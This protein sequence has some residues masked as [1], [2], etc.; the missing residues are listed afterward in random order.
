[1]AMPSRYVGI[2]H[3]FIRLTVH[4]ARAPLG[5][6]STRSPRFV[7]TWVLKLIS[8]CCASH[9]SKMD[10]QISAFEERISREGSKVEVHEAFILLEEHRD[11]ARNDRFWPLPGWITN[12]G[13]NSL[14]KSFFRRVEG[15]R[16]GAVNAGAQPD[17]AALNPSLDPTFA[18]VVAE[19]GVNTPW[20]SS[21]ALE[22]DALRSLYATWAGW[23][24]GVPE[25]CFALPGV[26][27]AVEGQV[28]RHMYVYPPPFVKLCARVNIAP[29]RLLTRND[30]TRV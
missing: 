23:R 16:R 6:R 15:G 8:L 20:Q 27:R 2:E 1:M 19:A 17:A 18:A 9:R 21:D 7:I 5:S 10:K 22:S 14:R 28:E 25:P 4:H 12:K 29:P 3:G 30:V 26:G 13:C 11:R 24:D